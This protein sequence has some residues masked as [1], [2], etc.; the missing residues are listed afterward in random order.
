M[1]AN[2][3]GVMGVERLLLLI[4]TIAIMENHLPKFRF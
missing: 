1:L 2:V 3:C 4:A